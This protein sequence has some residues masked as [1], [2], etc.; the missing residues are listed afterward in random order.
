[1]YAFRKSSSSHYIVG[2]LFYA[3]GSFILQYILDLNLVETV[4]ITFAAALIFIGIGNMIVAAGISRI[5][6]LIKRGS[7]E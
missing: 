2:I 7:K 3:I 5:T 4:G 6:N 1:M